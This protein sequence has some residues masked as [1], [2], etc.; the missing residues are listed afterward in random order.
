LIKQ[1]KER[2]RL[3]HETEDILY[4][5]TGKT[6][7]SAELVTVADRYKSRENDTEGLIKPELARLSGLTAS[8][9]FSSESF[10]RAMTALAELGD[11]EDIDEQITFITTYVQDVQDNIEKEK[12]AL[13]DNNKK[14]AQKEGAAVEK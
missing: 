1:F 12:N 6:T 4:I 3:K 9:Q 13:S 11:E 14:E 5:T 2:L 10:D 8:L 7:L